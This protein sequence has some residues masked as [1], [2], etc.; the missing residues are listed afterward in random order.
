MAM[1]GVGVVLTVN[2]DL[3]ANTR[4]SAYVLIL[5]IGGQETWALIAFGDGHCLFD[6]ASAPC[7]S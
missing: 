1:F 7:K 3:M 4:S 2:P 5:G 6:Q